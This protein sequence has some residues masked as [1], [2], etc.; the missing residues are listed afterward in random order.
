MYWFGNAFG[1]S[2]VK[3]FAVT[4]ALGV[5]VSLFTAVFVTRLLLHLVLDRMN[6]TAHPRLFGV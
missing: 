4:L 5:L 1:A 2:V 3:G 6:Y